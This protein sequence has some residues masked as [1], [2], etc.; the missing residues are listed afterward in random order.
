MLYLPRVAVTSL[1]VGPLLDGQVP[2][3]AD[4]II[5]R[6]DDSAFASHCLFLQIRNVSK[7]VESVF[8][9]QKEQT[10]FMQS[11]D[12]AM[13]LTERPRSDGGVVMLCKAFV[14]NSIQRW[15]ALG[16]YEP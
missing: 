14:I 8:V 12:K 5:D 6:I 16:G 1:I 10:C 7:G 2:F 13:A 15:A 3:Q 9:C 4:R 11:E